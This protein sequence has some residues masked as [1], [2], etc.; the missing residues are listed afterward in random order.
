ML[1][2]GGFLSSSALAVPAILQA[3]NPSLLLRQWQT[4]YD[5][6]VA[7]GPTLMISS[8]VSSI[9]AGYLYGERYPRTSFVQNNQAVTALLGGVITMTAAPWTL[10]GMANVN[11]KL[12]SLNTKATAG[13]IS[14]TEKNGVEKSVEHWQT[15]NYLRSL[16]PLAGAIVSFVAL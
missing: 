11:N 7:L 4:M 10:I 6:G 8:L 1:L 13:S 14:E 16:I 2:S 3:K 12:I 9:V 5:V 15:L